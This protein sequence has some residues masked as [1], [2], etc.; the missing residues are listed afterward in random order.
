[1]ADEPTSEKLYRHQ[2]NLSMKSMAIMPQK[3]PCVSPGPP[4][5]IRQNVPTSNQMNHLGIYSLVRGL[6]TPVVV[7]I[8]LA[9]ELC[10][11]TPMVDCIC[12]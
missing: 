5:V 1:M 10:P 2:T 12:T 7:Y 8:Y 9:K 6:W 3:S 4:G 11:W